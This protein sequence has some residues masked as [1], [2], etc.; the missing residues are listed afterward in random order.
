MPVLGFE[1]DLFIVA[2]DDVAADTAHQFLGI[3]RW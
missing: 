3:E 2:I 1:L